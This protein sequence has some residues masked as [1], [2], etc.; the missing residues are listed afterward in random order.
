[1]SRGESIVPERFLR[2]PDRVVT[3]A[4]L[5]DSLHSLDQD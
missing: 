1:V 5:G 2:H 3:K 4:Q